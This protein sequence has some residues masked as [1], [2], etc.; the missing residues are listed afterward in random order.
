MFITHDLIEAFKLGHRIAFM[1]DGKI[2]QVGK[3]LEILANPST[4]FISHFIKNLP[5]LKYFKNK[6]YFKR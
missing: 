2:I 3:P 1:R 4:D 5:V 6:R